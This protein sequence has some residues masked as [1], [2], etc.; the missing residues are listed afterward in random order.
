VTYQLS[1]RTVE[2]EG[3]HVYCGVHTDNG[4]N[5]GDPAPGGECSFAF[6]DD[7]GDK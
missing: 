2:Q 6:P 1:A 4:W 3:S 5:L 7:I